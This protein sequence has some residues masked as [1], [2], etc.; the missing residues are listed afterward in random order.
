MENVWKMHS[1]P[2]KEK[3]NNQMP[4]AKA[5]RRRVNDDVS[6]TMREISLKGSFM[7]FRGGASKARRTCTEELMF[8]GPDDE[9]EMYVEDDGVMDVDQPEELQGGAQMRTDIRG[10][11]SGGSN[12]LSSLSSRSAHSGPGS[13]PKGIATPVLSLHDFINGD[14]GLRNR[15]RML[16]KGKRM[17]MTV[18]NTG[19]LDEE[20][21]R[22]G[23]GRG[24]S[25]RQRTQHP[26]NIHVSRR[27]V[28][29]VRNCV[30]EQRRKSRK[31]NKY[32]NQEICS[33]DADNPEG[34]RVGQ[35]IQQTGEHKFAFEEEDEEHE[36]EEEEYAYEE[37]GEV[38]EGIEI[39]NFGYEKNVK[40]Q[41]FAGEQPRQRSGQQPLQQGEMGEEYRPYPIRKVRRSSPREPYGTGRERRDEGIMPRQE[42]VCNDWPSCDDN[43]LGAAQ[44]KTQHNHRVT[45]EVGI[46]GKGNALTAQAVGRGNNQL[47]RRKQVRFEDQVQSYGGGR[48]GRDHLVH[49]GLD[50]LDGQTNG[51]QEHRI[52]E[53]VQEEKLQR[54]RSGEAEA[55]D[56][57]CIP[58][59][60]EEKV[61]TE[62][63]KEGD[64]VSDGKYGG[65]PPKSRA[66]S[67]D[68]ERGGR[69]PGAAGDHTCLSSRR[70][71]ESKQSHAPEHVNGKSP[72]FSDEIMADTA[73]GDESAR[74]VDI[75]STTSKSM[76]P[77]ALATRSKNVRPQTEWEVEL[78]KG[79]KDEKHPD[80]DDPQ[81][82]ATSSEGARTAGPMRNEEEMGAMS[83]SRDSLVGKGGGRKGETVNRSRT[84]MGGTT[85]ARCDVDGLVDHDVD[86]LENDRQAGEAGARMTGTGR[87]DEGTDE[88]P[89]NSIRKIMQERL[90]EPGG[91]GGN[92]HSP[93]FGSMVRAVERSKGVK[94]Q[95]GSSGYK[96]GQER[97]SEP[98]GYAVRA[99]HSPASGR[100]N[101][102]RN[103]FNAV[104]CRNTHGRSTAKSPKHLLAS[105]TGTMSLPSR[106]QP[107]SV[108]EWDDEFGNPGPLKRSKTNM[109]SRTPRKKSQP[110]RQTLQDTSDEDALHP[111]EH[112]N[113]RL[114]HPEEDDETGAPCAQGMQ[115]V[116]NPLQIWSSGSPGEVDLSEDRQ[117]SSGLGLSGKKADAVKR[118]RKERGTPIMSTP[119]SFHT[120]A[121]SA[122]ARDVTVSEE[123]GSK[124]APRLYAE[125]GKV[126]SKGLAGD[127][128]QSVLFEHRREVLE[129]E[130]QEVVKQLYEELQRK[131]AAH[132]EWCKRL[133]DVISKQFDRL[134][135]RISK[136][137]KNFDDT[138]REVVT[139]ADERLKMIREWGEVERKS[140][141]D[142]I[143]M[144]I[145][146]AHKDL[147]GTRDVLKSE[148]VEMKSAFDV[149]LSPIVELAKGI[150][151]AEL[152]DGPP[153]AQ[154]S[155]DGNAAGQEAGAHHA[156]NSS[157][158][159][160]A[161][162]APHPQGGEEER[163]KTQQV[164]GEGS[165]AKAQQVVEEGSVAKTQQAVEEGSVA[166]SQQ[167]VED[168]SVAEMQQVAEEGT[169]VKAREGEV[170]K[171]RF[172]TAGED[173]MAQVVTEDGGSVETMLTSA[174]PLQ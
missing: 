2:V 42:R 159:A 142:C 40:F 70:Q 58:E 144:Y 172:A 161:C 97:L 60:L 108:L 43:S 8:Q 45:R 37:E 147:N 92:S 100:E 30:S 119:S 166:K 174:T 111:A 13:I 81:K 44:D 41:R 126:G 9:E 46:V 96:T 123:Y 127:S 34:F 151:A 29:G 38:G 65:P 103:H 150:P 90:S 76:E 168:G 73:V 105:P 59:P 16:M 113:N 169:D 52:P 116:V 112:V 68:E 107:R 102:D 170:A 32:Q 69:S 86:D 109:L 163:P 149:M 91:D 79:M 72:H 120:A 122:Q 36:E 21:C 137:E 121:A 47:R 48:L 24:N 33:D 154:Q 67:P 22:D 98:A 6:K 1:N 95:P 25:S 106:S 131:L 134:E 135:G 64:K 115:G 94:E 7:G 75:L 55:L 146:K 114:F 62:A 145:G 93:A 101:L 39:D 87:E 89:G 4:P 152:I 78:V 15:R 118:V 10:Q 49:R 56:I 17:T 165:V 14:E 61:L 66:C 153:I 155:A 148:L 31:P 3:A 160:E 26:E 138:E 20:Q 143:A 23:R 140:I 110:R 156:R 28:Y 12:Q 77:A 27:E 74:K 117:P 132:E 99:H 80:T 83:R 171:P 19:H 173:A 18:S 139:T 51:A 141:K 167:V 71:L 11:R 54:K 63:M 130:T 128:E 35:N 162:K 85:I 88:Q 50:L 82:V 125:P 129:V 53:R 5:L 133:K 84:E 157:S 136:L 124:D 158:S 57:R 104:D 164:V